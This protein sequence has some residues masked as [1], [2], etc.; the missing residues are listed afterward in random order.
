MIVSGIRVLVNCCIAA[1]YFSSIEG[2]PLA[3][4]LGRNT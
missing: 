1:V 3:K 4:R 2:K